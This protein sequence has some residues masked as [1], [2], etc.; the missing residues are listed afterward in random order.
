[1]CARC[2]FIS[3]NSGTCGTEPKVAPSQGGR[4]SEYHTEK[5]FRIGPLVAAKCGGH[6]SEKI[7]IWVSVV[8][9]YRSHIFDMFHQAM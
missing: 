3:L 4:I 8:F 6:F 5:I 1:M 2:G 7:V 9:C